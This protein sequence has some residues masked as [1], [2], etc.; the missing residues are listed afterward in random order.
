[1]RCHGG[2]SLL[3]TTMTVPTMTWE[4]AVPRRATTID[5]PPKHN[6]RLI[7][8][9]CSNT[10]SIPRVGALRL[11]RTWYT[12]DTLHRWAITRGVFTTMLMLSLPDHCRLDHLWSAVGAAM[13]NQSRKSSSLVWQA[14]VLGARTSGPMIGL[15]ANHMSHSIGLSDQALPARC[16]ARMLGTRSDPPQYDAWN[17]L[18]LC[19]F[20][21][22]ILKSHESV[23]Q[24][25]VRKSHVLCNSLTGALS[26][27][28]AWERIRGLNRCRLRLVATIESQKFIRHIIIFQ[29]HWRALGHRFVKVCDL[30]IGR[31][32]RRQSTSQTDPC[33]MHEKESWRTEPST[34]ACHQC[35]HFSSR[36][37]TFRV[38]CS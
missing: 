27:I 24:V 38:T 1:M 28:I 34:P 10:I 25:D 17:A 5:G 30:R 12:E 7:L 2:I 16:A 33:L 29:Q 8:Q 23:Q 18:Y 4:A 22:F 3:A 21:A 32:S 31:T 37:S 13:S 6:G 11:A 9:L 19:A 36:P 35:R 14:S 26:L 20:V 15:R